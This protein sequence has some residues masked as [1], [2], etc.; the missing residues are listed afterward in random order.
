M[1][2]YVTY[3]IVCTFI[4]EGRERRRWEGDREDGEKKKR[5]EREGEE[6][7]A[8]LFA[9]MLFFIAI[10]YIRQLKLRAVK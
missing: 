3:T 7:K 8:C 5:G 4:Q 10:L 6:T 1:G 2:R 9:W